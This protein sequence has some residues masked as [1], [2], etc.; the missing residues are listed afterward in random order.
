MPDSMSYSERTWVDL[1]ERTTEI[2]A[3]NLN[4]IEAFLAAVR[5]RLNDPDAMAS[6]DVEDFLT[7]AA[8]NGA[9]VP[10]LPGIGTPTYNLDGSVAVD[11][12]G[13]AWTYNLDGSPHT[14]SKGG[15]TLT[16]AYNLDGSPG[17]WS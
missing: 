1:P 14:A 17:G 5:N 10:A 2:D 3:E 7:V 4:R 6:Q 12:N 15:V 16:A 11:E 8:G 9:Y 13:V